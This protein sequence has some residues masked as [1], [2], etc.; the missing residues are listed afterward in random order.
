MGAVALTNKKASIRRLKDMSAGTE[1]PPGWVPELPKVDTWE[2][3]F[4]ISD[5]ASYVQ[6]LDLDERGH[7]VEWAVIQKVRT[8][9]GSRRVAVYD[10]CHD[11]G[12]HVHLYDRDENEFT[13][14][15]IMPIGSYRDMEQ[16]L[17]YAVDRVVNAWQENERR[18]DRGR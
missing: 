12:M 14:E 7:I 13:E 16:A 10:T 6:R 15:P 3:E 4:P 5:R 9:D 1:P 11:K 2:Q 17:D 18:S 8:D